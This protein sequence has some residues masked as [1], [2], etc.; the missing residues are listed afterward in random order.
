MCC[1]V[2]RIFCGTGL[3]ETKFL[4][5]RNLV[6]LRYGVWLRLLVTDVRDYAGMVRC[7]RNP[8]HQS[9]P[10]TW[11][12]YNAESERRLHLVMIIRYKP[13]TLTANVRICPTAGRLGIP[14]IRGFRFRGAAGGDKE[15]NSAWDSWNP[16]CNSARISAVST[17]NQKGI[18]E[19]P[20][21]TVVQY[22]DDYSGDVIAES[23]A[24]DVTLKLDSETWQLVLSAKSRGA[25]VEALAPFTKGIEPKHA[26]SR[27][28]S[29]TGSGG[30]AETGPVVR[31]WW[32]S[33]TPEQRTE[34]AL[35]EPPASGRG[36]IPES[37]TE[38]YHTAHPAE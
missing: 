8:A 38:A 1:L 29:T 34:L 36:K 28:T 24:L 10:W 30:T 35:P 32:V 16:V 14:I 12:D 19:M 20:K 7:A 33:L 37:V 13:V 18:P 26:G 5:L 21:Q 22:I 3:D 27:A 25:L 31:A 15:P 17:T 23:D 11:P 2:G 9:G 4:L 6:D